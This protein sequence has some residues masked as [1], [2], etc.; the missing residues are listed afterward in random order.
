MDEA[1]A[2]EILKS[3]QDETVNQEL[4]NL[5]EGLDNAGY[6]YEAGTN[7]DSNMGFWDSL[8]EYYEGGSGSAMIIEDY[9]GYAGV[10]ICELDNNVLKDFY[11]AD[12]LASIQLNYVETDVPSFDSFLTYL[13]FSSASIPVADG[14]RKTAY[15]MIGEIAYFVPLE[16]SGF[17]MPKPF[18]YQKGFPIKQL[19]LDMIKE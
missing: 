2:N 9:G 5:A 18:N 16:S 6:S 4:N 10:H 17:R 7:S 11:D 19:I 12:E 13:G 1:Q 3:V 15:S 8:K 14:E